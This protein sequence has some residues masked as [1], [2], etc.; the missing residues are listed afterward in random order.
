MHDY[1]LRYASVRAFTRW[2]RGKS[3]L[4]TAEWKRITNRYIIQKI[5]HTARQRAYTYYRFEKRWD[6]RAA[7]LY[8]P[9]IL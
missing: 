1:E 5:Y 8:M 6:L 9:W 3:D 2:L 4:G 7:T